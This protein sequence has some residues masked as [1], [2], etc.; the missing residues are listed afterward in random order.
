MAQIPDWA[1]Y[2]SLAFNKQFNMKEYE[3]YAASQRSPGAPFTLSGRRWWA[4][5]G[6]VLSGI[7][8]LV[9]IAAEALFILRD[10]SASITTLASPT[11]EDAEDPSG[12]DSDALTGEDDTS[13]NKSAT[14]ARRFVRRMVVR[15][16]K[17]ATRSAKA[18]A[19]AMK[20]GDSATSATGNYT[21]QWANNTDVLNM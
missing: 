11:T 13:A 4:A 8:I 19:E 9:A 14:D 6:H 3:A 16:A 1:P 10:A 7:A 18:K 17:N 2:D 5:A 20:D 12:P 21:C 15:A